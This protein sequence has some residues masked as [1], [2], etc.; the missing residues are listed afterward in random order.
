MTPVIFGFGLLCILVAVIVLV[1]KP[2]DYGASV[3]QF[4]K[5]GKTD[6]EPNDGIDTKW[7]SVRIRPGLIACRHIADLKGQVF[8]SREAP[9]LPLPSCGER[10]CRCHYVFLDDRRC[11]TDRRLELARLGEFLSVSERDRRRIPGR[12]T[13]DLV[14]A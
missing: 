1:F 9:A 2:Y 11:G 12:R 10:D 5:I 13:G 7:R 4:R 3:T 8:L 6:D 14:P